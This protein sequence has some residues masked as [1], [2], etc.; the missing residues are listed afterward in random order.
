[1][2]VFYN[3][4]QLPLHGMCWSHRNWWCIL[5][6]HTQA[7]KMFYKSIK[8]HKYHITVSL[9]MGV[10]VIELTWL[11][12]QSHAVSES[13][14]WLFLLISKVPSGLQFEPTT[15]HF[16]QLKIRREGYLIFQCSFIRDQV[17]PPASSRQSL[18]VAGGWPDWRQIGLAYQGRLCP[19]VRCALSCQ[20]LHSIKGA[21]WWMVCYQMTSHC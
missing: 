13:T 6:R 4:T 8:E 17:T 15:E 16:I 1:M 21:V 19:K 14:S 10:E 3:I 2:K 5:V 20:C 12:S 18:E 7:L 11:R 9:M